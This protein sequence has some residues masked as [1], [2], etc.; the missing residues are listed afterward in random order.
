MCLSRWSPG[1]YEIQNYARYVRHFGAKSA[2]G[3]PVSGTGSTRHVA[4]RDRQK[5]SR[6]GGVRLLRDTIDLS[7]ARIS[8]DFGQFLGTNLFL[9]EEQQ[10]AR[11]AEVRFTLPAGCR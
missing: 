8:G 11:P 1:S 3:Q 5:R 6:D 7:L 9:Y 2:Q 10:L 4:R